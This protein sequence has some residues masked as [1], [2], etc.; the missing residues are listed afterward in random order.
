VNPTITP[1]EPPASHAD[2]PENFWDATI[3]LAPGVQ[4]F[5][6]HKNNLII[7]PMILAEHEGNGDVGRMLDRLSAR[8]VIMAVT[9]K[10]LEGMLER[11]GYTMVEIDNCD[12]WART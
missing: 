11:R 12:F 9:S 4:G 5:A 7:I 6:F 10:R 1:C 2:C 3:Q 8:C